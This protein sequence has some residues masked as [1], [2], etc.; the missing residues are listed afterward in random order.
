MSVKS[1]KTLASR[2]D[3]FLRLYGRRAQR[4]EE[5]NDRRYDRKI[6]AQLSRMKPI[7]VSALITGG[8]DSDETDGR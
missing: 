5:P 7:D 4:G 1:R 6:E 3:E 8:D 2:I